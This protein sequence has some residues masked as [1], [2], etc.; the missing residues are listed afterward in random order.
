MP[1]LFN[2]LA[3][4]IST[5][6]PKHL[7][8]ENAKK[9]LAAASSR[10]KHLDLAG[11]LAS[12]PRLALEEVHRASH[13]VKFKPTTNK[14]NLIEAISS[15]ELTCEQE[16]FL[17]LALLTEAG[18]DPSSSLVNE[19][20]N[21]VTM[22]NPRDSHTAFSF[23][24]EPNS[25]WETTLL[26]NN[27]QVR[28]EYSRDFNFIQ[29]HSI[30]S[31]FRTLTELFCLDYAKESKPNSYLPLLMNFDAQGVKYPSKYFYSIEIVNLLAKKLETQKESLSDQEARSI[32]AQAIRRLRA[33]KNCPYLSQSDVKA[34]I[35]WFRVQ[36]QH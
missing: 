19:N 29:D 16:I 12:N 8:R 21:V 17:Y 4:K 9:R 32:C 6:K 15:G 20:L 36:G 30:K 24:S 35:D 10:I 14:I 27:Q 23:P 11:K 7:S 13:E 33:L 22:F 1:D 5:F 3:N 28:Q 25:I 2:T 18:L 26:R 31:A 34:N